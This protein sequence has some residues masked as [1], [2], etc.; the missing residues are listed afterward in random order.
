M[1]TLKIFGWLSHFLTVTIFLLGIIFFFATKSSFNYDDY[2]EWTLL[3][4]DI[5]Q[6]NHKEIYIKAFFILI[7]ILYILYFISVFTFNLSVRDFEKKIFIS[8]KHAKRFKVIG[9]IF[10]INYIVTKLLNHFI[11]IQT[12]DYPAKTNYVFSDKIF[13][14][15]QTPLGGLIIGFFFLVLSQVFKEAIKQKQENE[16]TI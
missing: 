10:I 2:S 4:N 8:L 11:L 14:E 3:I 15:F 12:P 9:F 13:T 1:N 6:T 16:L 5:P 7:S